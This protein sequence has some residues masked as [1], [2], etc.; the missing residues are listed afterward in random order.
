M[1]TKALRIP[2]GAVV[3]LVSSLEG[4]RRIICVYV[5]G[6]LRDPRQPRL[7]RSC[8]TSFVRSSEKA[9]KKRSVFFQFT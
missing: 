2:D 7:K 1:I 3:I 6:V 5:D 4:K 8:N 9:F